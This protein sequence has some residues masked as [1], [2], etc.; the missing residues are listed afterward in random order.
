MSESLPVLQ[1][2]VD[3]SGAPVPA[4]DS[5]GIF[6][7]AADIILRP[8]YATAGAA[9]EVFSPKGG[10]LD[11]VPGR[12]ANE[13]L[14]GIG[15]FKGQKETFAQVME[16]AGVSELGH[17]SDLAPFLYNDT[18]EGAAFQRGGWADPTGRGALGLA[19][20]IFLDPLR[21]LG[22]TLGKTAKVGGKF[23]SKTGQAAY[24]EGAIKAT[25][26]L[27]VRAAAIK[28]MKA[29]DLERKMAGALG[30][31][32][33]SAAA[34]S[35]IGRGT[36]AAPFLR[37]L[38]Q[39]KAKESIQAAINGGATDLLDKGGIAWF[40]I[41]LADNPI[42]AVAN[43][44]LTK[45]L[46]EKIAG[47]PA[48]SMVFSAVSWMKTNLTD[49]LGN[50]FIKGY[51]IKGLEGAQ[52]I[53]DD[54]LNKKGFFQH[55][56]HEDISASPL[57]RWANLSTEKRAEIFRPVIDAYQ[58]G[59]ITAVP[60]EFKE[61]MSYYAKS[62][63]K[64]YDQ[65]VASGLLSR[66]QK[67]SNY[68]AQ[69]YHN[70]VEE[71]ERVIF[72]DRG[73]ISSQGAVEN[74]LRMGRNA[75]ERVYPTLKDALEN[76]TRLNRGDKSIPILRPI[77]DPIDSLS[78]RWDHSIT[79]RINREMVTSLEKKFGQLPFDVN[80]VYEL[81]KPVKYGVVPARDFITIQKLLAADSK[82]VNKV[83]EVAKMSDAGKANYFAA[84]FRKIGDRKEAANVL[85]SY[86]QFREFFPKVIKADSDFAADG[87]V[88]KVF[89]AGSYS[90][91]LPKTLADEVAGLSNSLL[92]D[93]NMRKLLQGYD[94]VNNVWKGSVTWLFPA[95]H[96][97]NAYSN[98]A[99]A[100]VDIGIGALDP[101]SY[102]LT[103]DILFTKNPGIFKTATGSY[104]FDEVR[105]ILS[106]HGVNTTPSALAEFTGAG[107]SK[108][109]KPF[110]AAR[111]VGTAI[112]NESR[113]QL[114]L[115]YLRR[116]MDPAEV[117]SRVKKFELDYANGLTNFERT[118][119]KRIIPFYSFQRLNLGLQV[120]NILK[121]PGMTAT[122]LKPFMG[123]S[124]E[125]S[126]MT[127]WDAGA[128]KLRLN[129]DGKTIQMITG[130]DL[131]IRNLDLIFRGNWKDTMAN[132]V[133]MLTPILKTPIELAA[134]KS[135]FT[136]NDFRPVDV[137]VAGRI[138]EQLPGPIQRFMGYDK[139]YDKAGRP[140]YVMDGERYY[141]LAQ[142]Y[143][144]SRVLSTGDRQWREYTSSS[145]PDKLKMALDVLTGLRWKDMDMTKEQAKRIA[146]RK[147]DLE[148]ALVRW[149][150]RRQGTYTFKPKG[151]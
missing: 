111:E 46:T 82:V 63:E 57:A 118:W 150:K 145:E 142:S 49:R 66:K 52:P 43:S 59:G 35:I 151:Q 2:Q 50:L 127:S 20:D 44:G 98:V 117:G 101:A 113:A 87:S 81:S 110:A 27:G 14:S 83:A 48:G 109:L 146:E 21:G 140:K 96:V 138:V 65:E 100:F 71:L 148:E 131:P 40:G 64:M 26:D 80:K 134:G 88:F 130:I 17:F 76:S 139:T 23:L 119:M 136:G 9:E 3:I 116:G 25:E 5:P 12:V 53:I 41:R 62:V 91:I 24:V 45:E 126:Q 16:Q 124:D 108:L 61:A 86:D 132:A 30:P 99:Q 15:K 135:L 120:E 95:F 112:E 32:I 105:T 38:A 122:Q 69:Y 104:T 107:R 13:V 149:S 106:R 77:Y 92:R 78:R 11:A 28:A 10:G 18:G 89:N 60:A 128:L 19:G 1:Q 51:G 29:Q 123:R 39:A 114:A 129:K 147:R 31:E 34:N 72:K 6:T 125:N 121:R 143:L 22:S 33:N 133:G 58:S 54:A 84:R 137:P 47:T 85:S 103:A 102:K 68:F 141:L 42:H 55:L 7:R 67:L 144:L 36:S 93:K 37:D 4:Q 56:M 94:T 97:R 70:E 115:N 8:L 79:K 75:E 73:G 90:A 74:L